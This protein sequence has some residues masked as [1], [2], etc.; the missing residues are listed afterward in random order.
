MYVT[1]IQVIVIGLL[2]RYLATYPRA[3]PRCMVASI[4]VTSESAKLASCMS[5]V[6]W[7]LEQK[8]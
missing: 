5:A 7:I 2:V 1:I 3:W 4:A 8:C 6:G